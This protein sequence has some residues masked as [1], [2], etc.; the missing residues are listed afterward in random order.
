MPD[1]VTLV[2]LPPACP[3]LNATEN[4]WQYL[5]QTYLSNRLF[6]SYTAILDAGQDAWRKRV[7]FCFWVRS[8]AA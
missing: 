3:E 4:I 8:G 2:L 6:E 7:K 5:G 1:N